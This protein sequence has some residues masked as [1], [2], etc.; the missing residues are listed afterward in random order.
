MFSEKPSNS[1]EQS[2]TWSS[3]Y[4]DNTAEVLV[5]CTPDGTIDFVSA[6]YG[7]RI[8]DEKI[9]VKSG[10]LEILEPGENMTLY[11]LANY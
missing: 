7:G 10:F 3:Y 4:N 6:A 9:L 2:L 11:T 5:S 8:S 1:V